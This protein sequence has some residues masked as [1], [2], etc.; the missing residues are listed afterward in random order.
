VFALR[1]EEAGFAQAGLL[2]PLAFLVIIGTVLFQSV[3]AK[4]LAGWLEVREP[5]PDGFLLIGAGN[6]AR[7]VGKA[8]QQHG[9]KVLLSDSSW[10]NTRLARMEGLECYYGNAISEHAERHLDLVGIG[11]VLAISGR[12]NLD[13]LAGLRFK[14][15]FGTRNV[16][17][18]QST[19][20]SIM[21]SK[22]K[23]ATRHRGHQLFGKN[24]SYGTL[25]GWL[26]EGAEIRAT[27]LSETFD[28][29]AYLSKYPDR[30]IPLFALDPKQRAYMFTTGSELK[31]E[32]EWKV[33][34]LILPDSVDLSVAKQAAN[35]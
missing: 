1:L 5:P 24:I 6:V 26:R 16:Y 31:P 10:E 8:L 13:I 12:S 27:Q 7:A 4:R 28:F 22:Q 30:I 3:T 9:F 34:S 19:R 2:V 14:T 35:H 23:V 33:V 18:L 25:A 15:E 11:R 29:N 20:E 17:E 21:S 32:A